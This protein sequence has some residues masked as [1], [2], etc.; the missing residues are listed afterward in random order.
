MPTPEP[1]APTLERQRMDY[2][3][4]ISYARRDNGTGWV[5]ALRAEILGRHRA[6]LAQIENGD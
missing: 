1:A 4:F 3:L 2:E 6:V 5:T